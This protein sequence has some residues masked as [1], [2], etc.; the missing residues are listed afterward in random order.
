MANK[1]RVLIVD[2]IAETR[3][4][5]RKLLQ[6]E[7]DVEVVGIGRTGMEGIQF[8]QEM[9][10]DVVLMDINM[11][12]IDG[13]SATEQIRQ[14]SPHIQVVIL[15]VQGD[16][17]YMR[18][19][20]LAGARDFLTKPPMGDE[21]ISAI[22]RA[23]EMAHV[24]REKSAKQQMAISAMPGSA[25]GFG[26]LPAAPQGKIIVVYSPKGGTGCTTIAVNLS[27]ALNNEDTRAVLI[28]GNLQFGDVAIFVNEHG[29]NT[30]IDIAPRVDDLDAEIADEI[31]IKHEASGIRILAAPQRPE[32]AEKV[33]PDQF[34]KVLQFMQRIY[35][36]I[37]V[38]TSSIL[39]DVVLSAIDMSNV[40]VLVTTQEIPAIKNSRLI[41]DLLNTMSI[42]KERIVFAMNRY[43]KRV[44]I[45]P[46][47][48]GENLKHGIAAAIPFDE[49]TAVNAVNRGVPFMLDNK[50]QP[51]GKGIFA[52]AE[53]VRA[54]L[55]VMESGDESPAA[56]R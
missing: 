43:D 2:D 27:I 39:T 25:Q 35:S 31:L 20:M 49:K 11:P 47:R 36:Y 4:N 3:E 23:G 56:R 53:I 12:D 30:I 19:A 33:S 9:N 14:R 18:R 55:N 29:K 21:L 28:D 34:V 45:T 7:S 38:D 42:D 48:V 24:E 15:S 22:K 1:I 10:P 54:R 17:N 32:M 16:Q 41:L 40:I 5:V 52:L 13:I 44:A 6:F 26:G 51:I 50:S 37:V 46:E 8:A